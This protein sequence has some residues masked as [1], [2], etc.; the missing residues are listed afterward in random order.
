MTAAPPREPVSRLSLWLDAGLSS[1]SSKGNVLC[2]G[3]FFCESIAGA[4]EKWCHSSFCCAVKSLCPGGQIHS[5]TDLLSL[6]KVCPGMAAEVG[7]GW[8][9]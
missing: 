5:S 7:S 1:V 6:G 2:L 3:P 9:M 8:N 4:P